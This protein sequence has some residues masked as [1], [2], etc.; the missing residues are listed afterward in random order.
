MYIEPL[1]PDDLLA[2]VSRVHPAIPGE[3]LEKMIEF[4]NQVC[5]RVLT[6]SACVA[7]AVEHLLI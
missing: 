3:V 4:T 2:I 7:V 6:L 5:V 1:A